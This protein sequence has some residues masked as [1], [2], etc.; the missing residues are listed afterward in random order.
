MLI[1][2]S[3]RRAVY[4]AVNLFL[5][6]LQPFAQPAPAD[7]ADVE[8]RVESILSQMTLEE[9]VDMIGGVDSFFIRE[10]PRLNLPRLRMADGPLG[11]RNFA[12]ATTL[13]PGLPFAPPS[14]PH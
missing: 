10:L 1:Q 5:A 11:L 8:R 6:V 13:A 4:L 7:R 14:N 9:K 12:P 2:R 3:G